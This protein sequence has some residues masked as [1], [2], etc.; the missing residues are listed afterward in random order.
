VTSTL[1]P[2]LPVRRR[3]HDARLPGP[4]E[5]RPE[6]VLA[7]STAAHEETYMPLFSVNFLKVTQPVVDEGR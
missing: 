1:V 7:A 6:R 3:H 5:R 4:P 2:I